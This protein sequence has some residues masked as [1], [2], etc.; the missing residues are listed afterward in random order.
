MYSPHKHS[1]LQCRSSDVNPR[2]INRSV[3]LA[4]N[5]LTIDTADI[6]PPFLRLCSEQP[7]IPI[8]N[9]DVTRRLQAFGRYALPKLRRELYSK[10]DTVRIKALNSIMDLMHDPLKAYEAF[11]LK[12]PEKMFELLLSSNKNVREYTLMTLNVMTGLADGC[13][14]LV[15]ST[16]FLENLITVLKDKSS[17]VRIKAAVLLESL[18]K[19][20][21]AANELVTSGFIPIILDSL[22]KEKEAITAFYLKALANLLHSEGRLIADEYGAFKILIKLF[23]RTDLNILSGTANCIGFLA[24]TAQGKEMAFKA[25]VLEKLNK[26]LHD[27]NK[28]VICAA[29]FAIMNCTLLTSAKLRAFKIK[30]LPER[31]YA[32]S[33]SPDIPE[34]RVYCLQAL[35]NLCEHPCI[36]KKIYKKLVSKAKALN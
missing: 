2:I 28:E 17:G 25:D 13:N 11:K 9:V 1:Y 30:G 22:L 16:V 33:E 35:T 29:A 10:D 3:N 14:I 18:S 23:E 8:Q 5:Q 24:V 20:W 12:I 4:R 36:R 31:L 26:L 15:N 19:S 6:E 32:L 21:M 7:S 34:A 27:V